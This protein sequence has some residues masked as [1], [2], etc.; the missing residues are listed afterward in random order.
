MGWLG[1]HKLLVVVYS[2]AIAVAAVELT[3]PTLRPGQPENIRWFLDSGANVV[4]VSND[5]YPDRAVTL[6]Y[7]AYQASLCDGANAELAAC[8][9]RGPVEPGEV[10]ALLAR[11]LATGNRSMELAMYNYAMVLLQ[12]KADP[13]EV[14]AAIRNWRVSYPGSARLDPRALYREMVEPHRRRPR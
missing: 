1:A 8:K 12:E 7:R 5:L 3:H 4:T 14:D 10:R 6:Y 11:S 2:F 9:E 13:A